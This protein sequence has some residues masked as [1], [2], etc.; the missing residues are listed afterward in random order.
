MV[1]RPPIRP[2]PPGASLGTGLRRWQA[3]R[4]WA[5]LI[6]EAEALWSVDV[7][8]LHR[9]AARELAQLVQEVPP[10]LRRRVNQWLKRFRVLTRLH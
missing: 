5:R 4:T 10:G 3:A 2:S 7:R 1:S 8:V 6:R 9:L